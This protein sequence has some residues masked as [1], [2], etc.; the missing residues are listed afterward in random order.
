MLRS[1]TCMPRRHNPGAGR[2]RGPT[3]A[4]PCDAG[5]APRC[6]RGRSG[7]CC[8]P[9]CVGIALADEPRALGE[10][11]R[12]RHLRPGQD[13]G[14]AGR[15]G[16]RD[17]D[18]AVR[19]PRR[20]R[21]LEAGRRRHLDV[22][23]ETAQVSE[24][25]AEEG[26]LAA[27]QQE[28][29]DGV[30]EE[31]IGRIGRARPSARSL[32]AVVAHVERAIPVGAFRE[33]AVDAL[34]VEREHLDVALEPFQEVRIGQKEKWPEGLGRDGQTRLGPRPDPHR[35][36]HRLERDEAAATGSAEEDRIVVERQRQRAQLS[37][38]S[39]RCSSRRATV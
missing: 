31:A 6:T 11:L 1:A 10:Q 29:M 34:A 5:R 30:G 32:L 24:A 3:P 2:R 22:Q 21:E 23:R 15:V 36:A 33:P 4:R 18:D 37:R 17:G 28:L 12:F 39:N 13:A 14:E 16:E 26:G 8:A 9:R 19:L 35:I 25:H 7:R 38:P 27:A 20:V